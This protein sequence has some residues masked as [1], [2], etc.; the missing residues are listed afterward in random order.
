MQSPRK[1]SAPVPTSPV[2]VP[3]TLNIKDVDAHDDSTKVTLIA[4]V[5]AVAPA[6][7]VSTGIVQDI[8]ICDMS[9]TINLSV[10]EDNVDKLETGVTYKFTNLN[11]RSYRGVK[12]VT[13][14]RQSTYEPVGD[15]IEATPTAIDDEAIYELQKARN[16]GCQH[17]IIHIHC[18]NCLGKL[19]LEGG[20]TTSARC[21]KCNVFQFVKGRDYEV[22]ANVLLESDSGPP[23]ILKICTLNVKKLLPSFDI[24]QPSTFLQEQLLHTPTMRVSYTNKKYIHEIEID[25]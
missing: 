25:N 20:N 16:I 5:V 2:D 4:T 17:F 15:E 9:G 10:W 12:S 8:T 7:A 3:A 14:L 6:R 18:V 19:Q 11:I 13:L 23:V 21:T 24:S 1:F 22:A